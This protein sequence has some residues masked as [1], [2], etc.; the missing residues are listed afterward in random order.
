MG[1]AGEVITRKTEAVPMLRLFVS[2]QPLDLSDI[3]L[4]ATEPHGDARY[5]E[6]VIGADGL[7]GGFTLDFRAMRLGLGPRPNVPAR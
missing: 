3:S 1:G 2:G 7:R 6:G 5:R 4:L